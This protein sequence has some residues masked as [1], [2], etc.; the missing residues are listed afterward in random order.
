MFKRGSKREDRQ[1]RVMQEMFKD[2]KTILGKG[3]YT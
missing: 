3:R 2:D 1:V